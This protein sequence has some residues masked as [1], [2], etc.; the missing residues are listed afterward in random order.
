MVCSALQDINDWI[1]IDEGMDVFK[2][3]GIGGM[4]GSFLTGIFASSSVSL[5]DGST[6]APGGID[7]NGAQVARQLADISSIAA[8]S[9]TVSL[10]L[11]MIMKYLGKFVPFMALRVSEE[12]ELRGIDEDQFF[13][14][15]VGD[16]SLFEHGAVPHHGSKLVSTPPSPPNETVT[17]KKVTSAEPLD[18]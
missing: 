5:L 18:E 2:L 15:E 12:A 8:Y 6:D 14:E 13:E 10:C 17:E 9:F 4:V 16:W 7:G 1:H 3:H 11:L